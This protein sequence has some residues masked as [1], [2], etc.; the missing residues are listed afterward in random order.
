M[1][2]DLITVKPKSSYNLRSNSSLLLEPPK[3]KMLPT[4]RARS[5]YAAAPCLWNS[6]VILNE[7]LR[8]TFFGQARTFFLFI[9]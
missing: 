8:P 2:S 9:H 5:F 3:E 6:R 4:L 7:N 1:L